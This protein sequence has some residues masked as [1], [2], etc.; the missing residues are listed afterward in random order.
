M[1]YVITDTCIKDLLCV[2]VCPTDCI[3]PKGDETKFGAATQLYIDPWDAS[4]AAPAFQ[5]V[6]QTRSLWRRNCPKTRKSSWRRTL[7]ITQTSLLAMLNANAT[8]CAR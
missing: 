5:R 2:E 1:A 6:R 8:P 3:H 7:H 4:I